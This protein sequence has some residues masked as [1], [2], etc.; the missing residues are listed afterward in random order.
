MGI[1]GDGQVVDEDV[2]LPTFGSL[3]TRHQSVTFN[4]VRTSLLQEDI[5]FVNHQDRIPGCR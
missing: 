1:L 3:L 4:V 5:C 2:I